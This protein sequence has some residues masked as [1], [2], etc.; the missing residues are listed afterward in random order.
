MSKPWDAKEKSPESSVEK[1]A[2]LG[3]GT[4]PPS[5]VQGA[6]FSSGS[7][8][9]KIFTYGGTTFM[10]NTSFPGYVPNNP[11]GA[12]LWSYDT[13]A[14][15]W[16]QFSTDNETWRP[17]WGFAAEAPKL[18]LGFYFNGQIDDF[19]TTTLGKAKV[20]IEG[21]MV[22]DA[23]NR[24]TRNISTKS[25]TAENPRRGGSLTYVSDVGSKGALVL[26]GGIVAGS[27]AQNDGWPDSEADMSRI[28][29]FDVASL[30]ASPNSGSWYTQPAAGDIP[31]PRIDF[32][33]VSASVADGSSHTM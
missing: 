6:L 14:K 28:D 11:K 33:V 13:S 17:S 4:L 8:D 22:V 12:G 3:A 20:P 19:E 24:A 9:S 5:L 32:C 26:L 2:S 23:G 29:I 18:G 15:A 27:A 10:G 31:K 21:M 25:I 7:G 1:T 16:F 30:D